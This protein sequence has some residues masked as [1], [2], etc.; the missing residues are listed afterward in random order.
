MR[1]QQLVLLGISLAALA[2]CSSDRKGSAV[3]GVDPKVCVQGTHTVGSTT[4]G[5]IGD[6]SCVFYDYAYSQDSVHYDSYNVRLEQG[7]GYLFDLRRDSADPDSN[8]DSVLELY[9]RNANTGN[10]E[11][12]AIDDDAG[13]MN[14]SQL[15]FVAPVSGTFS[16][17]VQG[18]DLA[19]TAKYVLQSRTCAVFPLDTGVTASDLTASDC[20]LAESDFSGDSSRIRLFQFRIG[21]NETRTITVTS[22]DFVPSFNVYGPG[23]GVPCYW[24]YEGCGGGSVAGSG[25]SAT[26]TLTANG[27]EYNGRLTNFPGVYTLAVGSGALADIGSFHV[28]LADPTAGPMALRAR[29]DAGS[30]LFQPALTSLRRKPQAR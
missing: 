4:K 16:L 23:W 3:T 19:D 26:M 14:F 30:L 6:S 27:D 11:L 5:A 21:P 2:A 12:L 17:H 25:S 7:Q 18:Y 10:M 28:T 8:W 20:T 15:Y 22:N 9:G 24:G 29:A 13:R 1:H